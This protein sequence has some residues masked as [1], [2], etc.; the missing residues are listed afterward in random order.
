MKRNRFFGPIG[1][2]LAAV[3]VLEALFSAVPPTQAQDSA[4]P[5]ASSVPGADDSDELPVL[6]SVSGRVQEITA[7]TIKINDLVLLI[8]TGT[9]LPADIAVGMIITIRANLR[10]DDTLVI[11]TVALG[12]PT[13]SPTPEEDDEEEP[14]E[15]PTTPVVTPPATAPAT[16]DFPVVVIPDCDKPNQRL[17]VLVSA[18]YDV[19]YVEVVSWRCKGFTFGVIARAYLLVITSEGEGPNL[20]VPY[21]LSLRMTGR[22]W[23]IIIIELNLHPQ[24]DSLVIVVTSG[25]VVIVRDCKYLK[26]GNKKLYNKFCKKPKKPKKKK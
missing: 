6:L 12:T 14:T 20:T 3:L 11:I 18:T 10:N 4:T 17:A 1:I 24:P 7:T 21:I 13:P 19:P 16:P 25:Q 5:I 26:K 9:A 15:E 8:P 22:R 2:L 23:S